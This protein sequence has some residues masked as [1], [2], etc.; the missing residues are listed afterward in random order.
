L[1]S[2]GIP[3]AAIFG[4]GGETL[5][6]AERDFFR[7]ADPLGF[8]LFKRNCAGPS[9][10]RNLVADLRA[11]IRRPE[12]PV[13][14]DQ[15]GGRVARLQ[16]PHWRAYPAPGAIAALDGAAA[17][18]AAGLAARLIADDLARLGVSIDCAPVLDLAVTGASQVIGDRA[19]GSDPGEVGRLGRAVCDGLRQGG[20]LPVIKHIPGHGRAEIDSHAGLPRVEASRQILER[21]DF[22]P[23]RALNDMPW[24][25]T[26]HI[27]YAAID[28]DLPAT[29][30]RRV[31]DEAIR[32]SIGFQG[33]LV[34]D[35]LSMGALGGSFE[36]RTEAAL[37]AGCDVVLHCN[38]N[39]SEMIEVAKA[40]RPLSAR[41]VERLARGEK[42]REAAVPFDRAA[43]EA[44]LDA[45]MAGG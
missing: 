12:A 35:D 43:A 29:L 5:T 2:K 28:P 22:V 42:L 25:M 45:L 18:E 32:G 31:I 30:S 16:P 3:R 11:S 34:S 44:R 15:E 1:P 6:T 19:F 10:V 36:K 39:M 38:A 41:A 40:A 4:C 23:F 20:I 26:G 9:Q 21:G 33:V 17:H 27:V 14:I 13:L 7:A 24:A 8:I 37:A